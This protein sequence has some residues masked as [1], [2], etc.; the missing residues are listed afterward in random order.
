[1]LTSPGF[2]YFLPTGLLFAFKKPLI[3]LSFS[4][5]ISISYTSVLQRTFN[6][7]I[8]ASTV[9]PHFPYTKDD[10]VHP[11]PSDEQ[12]E[13]EFAMVDQADFDGIDKY[14]KK[15]GLNDE[16]LAEARR[17]KIYGVN[18][19]GKIPGR[20]DGW[21]GDEEVS[22]LVKA[23]RE[24]N[25]DGEM[26]EAPGAANE[27]DDSDEE[28]DENFDPGSEGESEG[29]GSNTEEEGEDGGGEGREFDDNGDDDDDEEVE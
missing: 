13:F 2:L 21:K 6:L 4:A 18:K 7:S 28:D 15:H 8:R 14:V 24:A 10:V 20:E 27:E 12:Q 22:E 11:A 25:G 3:F 5:I 26:G 23:E 19:N 1:M 9:P 29:S 16:S 17:A